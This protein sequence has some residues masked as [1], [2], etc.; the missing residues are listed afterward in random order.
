MTFI[1]KTLSK[2]Y[3]TPFYCSYIDTSLDIKKQ[4]QKL[5]KEL[6]SICKK[7]NPLQYSI[8]LFKKQNEDNE[9]GFNCVIFKIPKNVII[10]DTDDEISEARMRKLF[11]DDR[12]DILSTPSI[13]RAL[14]VNMKK[15]YHYYYIRDEKL[16]FDGQKLQFKGDEIGDMDILGA[17]GDDSG[18]IIE[19][20]DAV[21]PHSGDKYEIMDNHLLNQIINKKAKQDDDFNEYVDELDEK[22][23]NIDIWRKWAEIMPNTDEITRDEWLSVAKFFNKYF[24][25]EG[26]EIFEIWSEKWSGHNSADDLKMWNSIKHNNGVKVGTMIHLM[27]KYSKENAKLWLGCIDGK[28]TEFATSEEHLSEIAYKLLNIQFCYVN[29]QFYA[30]NK[31]IWTNDE[32]LFHSLLKNAIV[33]LKINM[34]F[35]DKSK[36]K[37]SGEIKY[38]FSVYCDKVSHLNSI[39]T[40]VLDKIIANPKNEMSNLFFNSSIGRICFNDG[41][42]NFRTK[43]FLKWD[44]DEL[45]QNPIFSCVKIDRDFPDKNSVSDKFKKDIIDKIFYSSM[46][47]EKAD[48]LIKFFSRALAGEI[49][50]KQYCSM[51]F[52]RDSAKGVIND[53]FEYTF[54]GYVGQAESCNFLIKDSSSDSDKDNGWLI[55]YQYNR[56][57]FVSEFPTDFKN[58]KMLVNS[59]LI[60]SI[61]SG[62]DT[63]RGRYLF[64]DSISFKLQCRTIFMCNDMPPYSTMD[65]CEKC[66][67][68][69]SCVQYK[70]QE[71]IDDEIKNAGGDEMIINALKKTNKLKDPELRRT[72]QT[73]QYA[74]ALIRILIDNYEDKEV[75]LDKK[76]KMDDGD[77]SNIFNKIKEI[78]EITGKFTDFLS[79]EELRVIANEIGMSLKKLKENVKLLNSDISEHRTGKEK[80]LV[81]IKLI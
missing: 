51:L 13:S 22:F 55:P 57:Q 34:R 61:N 70:T 44:S 41:V 4:K 37:E 21:L 63:M 52:S 80:G 59:K 24:P 16:Q 3:Q 68:I 12:L 64:K 1:L 17:G 47:C 81:G 18:F 67:D 39:Y 69:T 53:W 36:E 26:F 42:Y 65:V 50:D 31:N 38:I 32:R 58:K 15:G 66:L 75:L 25:D 7:Q 35:Q 56:F 29:K 8:D 72:V 6:C 49:Q 54:G 78:L 71:Q 76:Q 77:D 74:N 11:G 28:T 23:K 46:D 9:I 79:N 20:F 43:K 60:K 45:K 2:L 27:N 19:H 62:G 14:G 40:R 10:V 48:K 33:N 30:K 73:E 5:S